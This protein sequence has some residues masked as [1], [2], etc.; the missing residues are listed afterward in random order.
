[1][2]SSY[3]AGMVVS[4][5]SLNKN[6]PRWSIW[7]QLN[8]VCINIHRW[9]SKWQSNGQC[10]LLKSYS[11]FAI[12]LMVEACDKFNCML[13]YLSRK[14]SPWECSF[15]ITQKLNHYEYS[16]TV[17][18]DYEKLP[19]ISIFLLSIP[20]PPSLL[21]LFHILFIRQFQKTFFRLILLS[22]II[23]V[24]LVESLEYR[25]L[26]YRKWNA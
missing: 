16:F 6:I 2:I 4:W 26:R 19:L 17:L 8:N 7:M 12:K 23:F 20:S 24:G 15:A 1:M 21:S 3:S 9:A 10:T 25:Y 11:S 18:G 14:H 22:S 13:Y 5:Y